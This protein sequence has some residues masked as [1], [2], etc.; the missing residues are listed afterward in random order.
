MLRFTPVLESVKDM[1]IPRS[2]YQLAAQSILADEGTAVMMAA[3]MYGD[4]GPG[5]E[6]PPTWN[7]PKLTF[8]INI[9]V[10][11]IG[12]PNSTFPTPI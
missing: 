12:S 5:A 9:G 8:E 11:N 6:L 3:Y 7:W 4:V 2:R 1:L 10:L